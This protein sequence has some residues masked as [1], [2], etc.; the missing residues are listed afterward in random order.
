MTEQAN[1]QSLSDIKSLIEENNAALRNAILALE[2]VN[3][4]ILQQ[5]SQGSQPSQDQQQG[6]DQQPIQSPK[7]SPS[8][9][10]PPNNYPGY[11]TP[12]R[13]GFMS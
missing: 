9:Q 11:T 2:I 3:N 8:S 7:S 10:I 1:T 12:P 4:R 5:P 13:F 6:Q